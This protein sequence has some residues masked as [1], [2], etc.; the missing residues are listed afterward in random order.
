MAL[1]FFS[2]GES[3]TP[4]FTS[5]S[6]NISCST[7]HVKTGNY[8]LYVQATNSTATQVF[9]YGLTE[10]YMTFWMYP[11]FFSGG[12]PTWVLR[13]GGN[14]VI[15]WWTGGGTPYTFAIGNTAI[16]TTL[17]NIYNSTWTLIEIHVILAVSGLIHVRVNGIDSLIYTGN[18]TAAGYSTIDRF[19][20]FASYTDTWIDDLIFNDT[21]GSINNSWM[22]GAKV[23]GL[24]PIGPGSSTQWTPSVG[25]NWQCVDEVPVSE[26][27]YVTGN[28]VGVTDLYDLASLPAGVCSDASILG[29]K[30]W[31]AIA[32]T[33]V[34]ASYIDNVI[35]T[36]ASN[37]L[38]SIITVPT[39]DTVMTS[40]WDLNPITGTTWTYTDI[41]ALEVG[42][43]L[44]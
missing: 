29:I 24:K 43:K 31:N 16:G 23:V 37:A 41:N 3:G 5:T 17:A 33:G 1:I 15:K 8:S 22:G 21:T 38:S 12:Q 19:Y 25:A 11:N 13:N 6:G 9:P 34:T 30:A 26:A 4:D 28:I 36:N 27:D 39:V 7:T 42:V 18:T 32:R 40:L 35:R 20:I 44:A 2:G 10:L 14:D